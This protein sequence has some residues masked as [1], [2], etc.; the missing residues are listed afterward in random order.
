MSGPR[1]D[2]AIQERLDAW[3]VWV[4]GATSAGYG[5]TS[6]AALMDLASGRRVWDSSDGV[7][8][9]FVPVDAIE[10]ERTD[11]AV[12]SLPAELREAVEAWHV[13]REGTLDSVARRLGIVRAT[14]HRRLC[15]AD[16][17]VHEWLRAD[18]GKRQQ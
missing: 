5:S 7:P 12:R 8:R 9:S 11:R 14:L 3:G 16:I 15:Q 10:C 6:I 17:R 13:M 4:L 2:P 18:K 1:R